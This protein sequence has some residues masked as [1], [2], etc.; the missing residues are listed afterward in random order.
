MSKPNEL[1]ETIEKFD[2]VNL[3]LDYKFDH[4]QLVNAAKR[5]RIPTVA[6]RV[7]GCRFSVENF[8]GEILDVII[9][10]VAASVMKF[11]KAVKNG[12]ELQLSNELTVTPDWIIDNFDYTDL[13]RIN[14]L[15]GK[16]ARHPMTPEEIK[17]LIV[18][19]DIIPLHIPYTI[20]GTEFNAAIRTRRPVVRDHVESRGYSLERWGHHFT[21]IVIA[22]TA[23]RTMTFG[24]LTME[25]GQPRLTNQVD[26]TLAFI[27]DNFLYP[28]LMLL[29]Q[30]LV[31]SPASSASEAKR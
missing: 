13:L 3:I 9:A 28:D 5:L 14:A 8:D 21:D 4:K 6:D 25:N 16:G 1:K 11:G 15:M 29:N 30:L 22:G 19:N 2:M 23:A 7:S 31:K 18:N 20:H 10:F 12:D 17:G 24:T 27:V 26:V